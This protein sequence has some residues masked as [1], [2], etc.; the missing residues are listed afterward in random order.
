[1][2]VGKLLFDLHLFVRDDGLLGLNVPLHLNV[3]NRNGLGHTIPEGD[4]IL[5]RVVVAGLVLDDL[6]DTTRLVSD[7]VTRMSFDCGRLGD[8]ELGDVM[9]SGLIHHRTVWMD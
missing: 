5:P 4:D 1:M 2:D 6:Q 8:D 7:L 3:L 9:G